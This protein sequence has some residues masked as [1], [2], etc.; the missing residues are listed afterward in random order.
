MIKK[1]RPIDDD[2]VLVVIAINETMIRLTTI[3]IIKRLQI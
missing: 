2:K 3:E 1:G